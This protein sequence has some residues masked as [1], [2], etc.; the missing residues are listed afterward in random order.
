MF[1]SSFLG[2]FWNY[3]SFGKKYWTTWSED[4]ISKFSPNKKWGVSFLMHTSDLCVFLLFYREIFSKWIWIKWNWC[5]WEETIG[6]HDDMNRPPSECVFGSNLGHGFR[7]KNVPSLMSLAILY[8][9][10][11]KLSVFLLFFLVCVFFSLSFSKL[12]YSSHWPIFFV[13]IFC[14]PL[15]LWLLDLSRVLTCLGPLCS[16]LSIHWATISESRFS[17]IGQ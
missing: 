15:D 9:P 14:G 17:L 3:N 2:N 11:S 1:F 10:L 7:N 5:M 13:N 6:A 8:I 16:S 4:C 12:I